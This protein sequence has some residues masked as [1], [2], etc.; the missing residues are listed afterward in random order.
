MAGARAQTLSRSNSLS[1][2]RSGFTTTFLS[3]L[4]R[5]GWLKTSL[6]GADAAQSSLPNHWLFVRFH[7]ASFSVTFCRIGVRICDSPDARVKFVFVA[8]VVI[9]A[10]TSK[11][12]QN[13]FYAVFASK[14]S[15]GCRN[16]MRFFFCYLRGLFDIRIDADMIETRTA[17]PSP[18]KWSEH[19]ASQNLDQHN[20]RRQ[21]LRSY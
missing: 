11:T 4:M 9:H 1:V 3:F 6:Q 20:S 19:H 15:D 14:V 21:G 5:C 13:Y 17:N 10:N 2:F 12:R 8:F 7:P 18:A 16:V